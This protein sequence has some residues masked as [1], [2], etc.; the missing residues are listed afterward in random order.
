[1]DFRL[2]SSATPSPGRLSCKIFAFR[3]RRIAFLIDR[4]KILALP[5]VVAL[6]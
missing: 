5:S 2:G 6:T 3:D 4:G 1:M